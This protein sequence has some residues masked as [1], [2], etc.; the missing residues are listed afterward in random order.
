LRSRATRS[1]SAGGLV[2]RATYPQDAANVLFQIVNQ[3]YL[4]KKAIVVTTNKPLDKW[5]NVLHARDLA[6]AI[7]DRVLARNTA[8]YVRRRLSV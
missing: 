2:D 8:L 4:Q 5:A 1:P 3:R 7:I 6:E